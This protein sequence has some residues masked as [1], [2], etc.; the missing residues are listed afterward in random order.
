ME[1]IPWNSIA[2]AIFGGVVILSTVDA[3]SGTIWDVRSRLMSIV[4]LSLFVV[5]F[6]LFVG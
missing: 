5:L 4:R 2:S 3:H 1:F 6:V